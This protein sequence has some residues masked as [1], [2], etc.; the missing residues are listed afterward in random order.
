M[1]ILI[2]NRRLLKFMPCTT[3]ILEETIPGL[4]KRAISVMPQKGRAITLYR[5]DGVSY[6]RYS[7]EL[8][9][10]WKACQ[11]NG[12]PTTKWRYMSDE[13]FLEW[14]DTQPVSVQEGVRSNLQDYISTETPKERGEEEFPEPQ[15]AFGY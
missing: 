3:N 10:S 2:N 4:F 6:T 11:E 14:V 8:H 7:G 5:A 15:H 9:N 13:E 12:D 1:E